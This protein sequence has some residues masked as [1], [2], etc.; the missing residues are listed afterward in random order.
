[1]YGND[2]FERGPQSMQNKYNGKTLLCRTDY[3]GQTVTGRI[4][5]S[6]EAV[7]V[8][9]VGFE[10]FVRFESNRAIPLQLEDNQ[11]CTVLPATTSLG[12]SASAN[13]VTY[14]ADVDVRQA[15]VGFRPWGAGDLIQEFQFKL[16][17][18]NGLFIAPDIQKAIVAADVNDPPDSKIVEVT[19]DG[20]TIKISFSYTFGWS[21][22]NFQ[23]SDVA[24][25]VVFDEGKTTEQINELIGTLGTFFTAAAGIEV[26]LSDYWI[27]PSVDNEQP[28]MGG[29]SAPAHFQLIW[30]T[31][32]VGRPVDY[33]G[34]KPTGLLRCWCDSDR[35]TTTDCLRF[36][37]ENWK[38]WESAFIGM[39]VAIREG[40]TFGPNRIV[41]AC[42]WFESTPGVEQLKVTRKEE[43]KAI[44][45]AAISKAHDLGLDI[46]GRI[47][48]AIERLR[49]ESR[50]QLFERLIKAEKIKDDEALR[51]RFLEDLLEAY[52]VRGDFAHAKFYHKSDDDF[53]QY[54]RVTRAVEALAFLLLF[55]QLPLPD[56]HPWPHGPNS[57]TDYFTIP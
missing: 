57:F 4:S 22:Q 9:I 56:D 10:D 54:V 48:G 37:V 7:D 35:K 6:T 46:D 11:F 31:G 26:W 23:V 51:T 19:T 49:T 44:S 20:I 43:L 17:D 30:P 2:D 29:G 27:K 33:G 15:I 3:N 55:R 28:L 53:G 41:N 12:S 38:T 8:K 21:D 32:R 34:L 5:M 24:G 52:R 1:M 42:K 47:S 40:N 16:S 50:K 13:L 14:F 45:A 18:T 39:L 36:W 25:T